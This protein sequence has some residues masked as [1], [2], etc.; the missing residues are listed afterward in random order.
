MQMA[1]HNRSVGNGGLCSDSP[2]LLPNLGGNPE[3]RD[4]NASVYT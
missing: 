1:V 2:Y 4:P 3:L